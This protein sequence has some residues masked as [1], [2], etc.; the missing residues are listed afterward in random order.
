MLSSTRM[1]ITSGKPR[2]IITQQPQDQSA[3]ENEA[4]FSVVATSNVQEPLGYQWQRSTDSGLSWQNLYSNIG[5]ELT[6]TLSLTW[7]ET[8]DSGNQYRV[9]ITGQSTGASLISVAA[10][11]LVPTPP[12]ILQQPQAV[13]TTTGNPAT[14]SVSATSE[15]GLALT[16]RWQRI[17]GNSGGSAYDLSPAQ[18]SSTLHFPTTNGFMDGD[19]YGVVITDS[20]GG[21]RISNFVRLG[22]KPIISILSI[23][24]IAVQYRTGD[25]ASVTVSVD[26]DGFGNLSYFWEYWNATPPEIWRAVTTLNN[27]QANASSSGNTLF[28]GTNSGGL[29]ESDNARRFRVTVSHSGVFTNA[30]SVVAKISTAQP[31]T[32]SLFYTYG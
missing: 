14:F 30:D 23:S 26:I 10:V 12:T 16:Y 9:V 24:D 25:T 18:T 15:S 8:S 27:P 7:L 6:P 11:L 1:R 17:F 2:I 13:S 4:A 21:S 19:Y 28:L 5:T 22:V 29:K 31:H 3:F 20:A 32:T